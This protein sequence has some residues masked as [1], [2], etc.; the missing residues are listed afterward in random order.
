MIKNKKKNLEMHF[1]NFYSNNVVVTPSAILYTHL[2]Y[3][4]IT[5][6]HRTRVNGETLC[7]IN[8]MSESNLTWPHS[9]IF[10][11]WL[12]SC[13]GPRPSLC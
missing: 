5:L 2:F 1:K 7:F 3:A 9:Q 4:D 11:S 13:S 8:C 10:F 6:S 12:E